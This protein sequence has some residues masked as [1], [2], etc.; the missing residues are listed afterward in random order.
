M[1][2]HPAVLP[3][4]R[5][6][7]PVLMVVIG[8]CLWTAWCQFPF[9]PWNDARLAP[10][11]ALRLGINPY[12]LI[13][14]GPLSTWIYGPVG[15]FI[16]L[17]ATWA[18]SAE[19]ALHI[20]SLINFLVLICPLVVIFFTATALGNQVPE[21]RWFAL[22]LSILLI[23]QPNF[24]F[25]VADHI[26]V[27]FGI[28]SN[29]WLAKPSKLQHSHYAIAAAF[30][31]LAI[32]SKQ[33]TLF[34]VPAQLVYLVQVGQRDAIVK[35]VLWLALW[36]F[37]ALAIFASSFGWENLWL[38]LVVIP[39]RLP[40]A[41]DFI[42]RLIRR[43]WPLIA[44]I[45]LPIIGLTFLRI[46]KIWPGSKTEGGRFFQLSVMAYATMLPIG[47]T[48][49]AKIGGDTNL[50][51]SWDYLLPGTILVWLE[52]AT[53]SPT[54][55]IRM[56]AA[57]VVAVCL[58]FT[59]LL[60]LPSKPLTRHFEH[61]SRLAAAHP[62]E[63]WF[64]RNPVITYY[65]DGKLWQSEDGIQTRFLA[66]YGLREADFRRYL[67]PKLTAVAYPAQFND[68]FSMALL[69]ELSQTS[70]VPDWTVYSRPNLPQGKLEK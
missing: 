16:N 44:Q 49:F 23:P 8:V 61:A 57:A 53:F 27:A 10:A 24:V 56:I 38:N 21:L 65:A 46:K 69:S 54:T 28:F 52:S 36:G 43:R 19:W 60:S 30:C 37:L 3:V 67:P 31:C 48:G 47:L 34:L 33:I 35:Y 58:H 70:E 14:G 26:A 32:W 42:A 66:H 17:P 63:I 29:W 6:S 64:P 18:T 25:Q 5:F 62:H 7:V 2:T 22:A 68:S 40:W 15:I 13:G 45:A 20:A 41:D 4:L 51:H 1:R 11:F 39:E 59:D 50:L 12:P 55:G 9:F